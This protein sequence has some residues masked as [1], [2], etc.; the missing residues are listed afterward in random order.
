MIEVVVF[1]KS[2]RTPLFDEIRQG[3]LLGFERMIN[4]FFFFVVGV[5]G[6]GDGQN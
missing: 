3:F 6:K 2:R 4:P 1:A 5:F